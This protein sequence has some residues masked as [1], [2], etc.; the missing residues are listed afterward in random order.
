[1]TAVIS[2]DTSDTVDTTVDTFLAFSDLICHLEDT[3]IGLFW[4]PCAA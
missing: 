3:G 1:M 2:V 4:L